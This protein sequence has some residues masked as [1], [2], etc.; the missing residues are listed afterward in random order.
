MIFYE[1]LLSKIKRKQKTVLFFSAL[2]TMSFPGLAQDVQTFEPLSQSEIST[3]LKDIQTDENRNISLDMVHRA[4]ISGHFTLRAYAATYLAKHGNTQSIS[5]L[6]DALSDESSHS[7]AN[8]TATDAGLAT[9][10]HRAALSLKK[11]THEDFGYIW[12]GPI[13]SREESIAQWR[14]WLQEHDEIV[15]TAQ[16]VLNEQN[17]R[18][19]LYTV[20]RAYL[21][22]AKKKWIIE[23]NED[24]PYTYNAIMT[25]EIERA[26]LDEVKEAA[27]EN[28]VQDVDFKR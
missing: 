7:G 3:L 12:N 20:Q 9:T 23:V 1:A 10:R 26:P 21:D 13:D 24:P 16:N 22:S 6:I 28:D 27:K 8:Y 2:C 4:L 15:K 14:E 25:I 19:K 18:N 5:L 11:L 17:Q